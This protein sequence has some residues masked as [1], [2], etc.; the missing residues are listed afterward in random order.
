MRRYTATPIAFI[1]VPALLFAAM[2]LA[3]IAVFRG[4]WYV[5]LPYLV[6]ALLYAWFAYRTGALWMAI[7]LHWANNL[8]N[9]VLVGTEI[10][11]IPSL[12]P[13][14]IEHPSSG[15]VLGVTV[16]NALMTFVILE[17]LIRGGGKGRMR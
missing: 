7:G 5:L 2:H 15:L 8:G 17:A 3:N 16:F 9:S 13:V 10:D 11:V 1:G 14:I 4:R 6:S 12:A